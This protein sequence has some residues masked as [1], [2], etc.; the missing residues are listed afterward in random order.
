LLRVLGRQGVVDPAQ[1]TTIK[2]GW[3]PNAAATFVGL[4]PDCTAATPRLRSS[5]SVSW[6]NARPSLFMA[7]HITT[8]N[9]QWHLFWEG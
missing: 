6:F 8:F 3:T 4:S 1:C 9:P 7:T 2:L 5:V